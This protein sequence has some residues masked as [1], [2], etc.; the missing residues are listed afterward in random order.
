MNAARAAAVREAAEEASLV[1]DPSDL[2]PFSFWVP[3]LGGAKR[4]ATW[5]FLIEVRNDGSAVVV[6]E[7]EIHRSE[8]DAGD[9]DR[10]GQRCPNGHGASHVQHQ[11]AERP[12]RHARGQAA[13]RLTRTG[14]VSTR[15]RIHWGDDRSVRQVTSPMTTRHGSRRSSRSTAGSWIRVHGGSKCIPE[16][17]PTTFILVPLSWGTVLDGHRASHTDRMTAPAAP[18]TLV[19]K[20]VEPMGLDPPSDRADCLPIVS[21]E[22]RGL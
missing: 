14:A 18:V 15:I 4:F 13:A 8:D 16:Q 20:G 11:V 19:L 12:D 17:T 5:F 9:G 6:D 2:V 1:L 7:L 3:P 21:A 22:L 10:A